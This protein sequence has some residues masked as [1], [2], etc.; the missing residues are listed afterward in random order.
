MKKKGRVLII[1]GIICI[2]AALLLI[3]FNILDSMRADK[4]IQDISDKFE[5]IM[6]DEAPNS[7]GEAVNYY[8]PEGSKMPAR[9]IDERNYIGIL[10]IPSLKLSLPVLND[11]SYPNL[12]VAPCRYTGN[13]YEDNM[14]IAAHNYASHFGKIKKLAPGAQVVFKDVDGI[15]YN[16]EVLATEVLGSHSSAE[17]E[18]GEWDLTLF[19][20]TI[21]GQYRVTVRCK[22]VY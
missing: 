21:G 14:I 8:V 17:M 12:R 9:K 20:C 5:T 4:E 19:T 22:R 10:E 11:W 7:E 13:V 16:Y 18:S 6:E 3:L 2:A 15:V 1:A